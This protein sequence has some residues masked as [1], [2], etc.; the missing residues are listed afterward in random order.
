MLPPC[1]VKRATLLGIVEQQIVVV[2]CPLLQGLPVPVCLCSSLFV[3][4]GYL[5]LKVI[6]NRQASQVFAVVQ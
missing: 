1:R 4:P 6:T 3:V 5:T 2:Q